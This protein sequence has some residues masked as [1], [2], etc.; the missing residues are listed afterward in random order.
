MVKSESLDPNRSKESHQTE[1]NRCKIRDTQKK[2]ARCRNT[3][4]RKEYGE[5]HREKKRDKRR[6]TEEIAEEAENAASKQHTKTLYT[7]TR[8]LRSG[9]ERSRQSAAVMDKNGKTLNDKEST[10]KRWLEHFTE[11]LNGENPSNPKSETE[12]KL[13]DE[14]EE[15]DTSEPGRAEVRKA[16]GHPKNAGKVPGID[17]V[18]A[19]LLTAG[20]DY[21]TTKDKKIIDVMWREEKTPDKWRKGLII[22]LPKKGNLEEC[23]NWRGIY[24]AVSRQ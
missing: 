10:T 15:I 7:L 23:K 5:E 14:V 18:Q 21:A 16:I 2:M 12:I 19:E 9:N 6:R 8:V 17:N 13:P 22:K 3:E 24:A 11:V 4:R 1:L 20:I